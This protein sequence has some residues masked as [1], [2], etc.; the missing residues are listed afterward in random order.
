M[1]ALETLL[2]MLLLLAIAVFALFRVAEVKLHGPRRTFWA[3][4]LGY[5]M[6]GIMSF[7]LCVL[8]AF[9]LHDPLRYADLPDAFPGVMLLAGVT[10]IMWSATCYH[11][12]RRACDRRL[13]SP[14]V[15][16]VH[17]EEHRVA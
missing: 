12:R 13:A 2:K 17:D 16:P 4:A 3:E 9:R 8:F 14:Q 15:K 6:T 10:L 5:A 1:D 7:W 11:L